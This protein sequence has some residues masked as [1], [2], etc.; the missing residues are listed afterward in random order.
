MGVGV[1]A[2]PASAQAVY[3]VSL[4]P[5]NTAASRLP[6]NG[7]TY[8]V[9][10][11]VTDTTTGADS[12][13]YD[14]L[15]S[16]RPGGVLTTVSITG[17]GV[18]QDAN[19]DSARV[20]LAAGEAVVATIT[21]SVGNVAAGSIDTLVFL[22]RAVDE[23]ATSDSAKL[24]VTVIRPSITVA[25]SVNPGG[26]QPPGTNL[27]YTVAITNIGTENAV[28][29]VHVDSV[30]AQLGFKLGSVSTTLPGGVTGTVAYSNN[31]T[32]WTYTPTS[33]GCGASASYDY[34]VRAIRLSLNNPLSHVG[35]NNTVQLEFIAKVK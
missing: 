25:K 2:S 18:T 32:T 9:T 13:T 31:G 6:S 19:P 21:Y 35:P 3:G 7:T 15:T 8:T 23:P 26:T 12:V 10:F 17:T 33:G 22:A 34:C 5:H 29:V 14:L 4:S 1:G 16:Q 28:D 30:P 11:S 20:T 24:V 27:T